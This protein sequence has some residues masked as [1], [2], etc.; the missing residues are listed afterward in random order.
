MDAHNI[1]AC[2]IDLAVEIQRRIGPGLLD[3]VYAT[4][5]AGVLA[6]KGFTVERRSQSPFSFAESASIRAPEHRLSWEEWFSS[7]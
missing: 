7:N 3:S 5:L 2:V 1:A 4:S 6:E